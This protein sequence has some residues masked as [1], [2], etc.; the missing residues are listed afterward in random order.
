[1]DDALSLANKESHPLCVAVSDLDHFKQVYDIYWHPAGD[2]VLQ[3]VF[4]LCHRHI[5][6]LGTLCRLGG[7]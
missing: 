2:L 5:S 4:S 1:V 6:Q 3:R 7:E